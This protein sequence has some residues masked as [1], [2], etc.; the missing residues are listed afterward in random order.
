MLLYLHLTPDGIGRAS[1]SDRSMTCVP[2][3][4]S[5]AT[6][7]SWIPGNRKNPE[8]PTGKVY[9]VFGSATGRFCAADGEN[10]SNQDFKSKSTNEGFQCLFEVWVRNHDFPCTKLE[11]SHRCTKNY[12]H[13]F[14]PLSKLNPEA[15]DRLW[16]LMSI[17]I[18]KSYMQLPRRVMKFSKSKF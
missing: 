5:T 15:L 17:I 10:I 6:D 2:S 11:L 18:R 14:E 1:R 13:D 3:S 7:G 16:I 9:A 12:Q 4:G 8:A